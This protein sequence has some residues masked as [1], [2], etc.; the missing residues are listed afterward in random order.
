PICQ[1]PLAPTQGP[2][3]K[4]QRGHLSQAERMILITNISQSGT[5]G[6]S[7]DSVS[8]SNYFGTQP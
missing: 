1:P 6:S 2:S 3:S 7:T 5:R 8:T 4:S